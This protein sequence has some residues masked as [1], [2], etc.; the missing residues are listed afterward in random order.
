MLDVTRPA[1]T[2]EVISIG[3][4]LTTGRNLD[5]N[6]QWLSRRLSE[7]GI[8]VKFHTTISDDLAD[9]VACFRIASGRA[10]FVIAT[11]GLGP[12]LDDLTRE[13]FAE[14]AGVGLVEHAESLRVISHMFASRNRPMPERNRVQAL[15]PAGAEVLP[16]RAGTAPGIWLPVGKSVLVAM[17]G[18][19]S[20]MR[21]MYDEQVRPRLEPLGGGVVMQRKINTFGAGESQVEAMLAGVTRRGGN[22]EVGI[23]ASDALISLRIVASAE[24][25]AAADALIAPVEA[26]IRAKLGALVFG[27]DDDTLAGAVV[28]LALAQ[29]ATVAAAESVSG[30][31]AAHRLSGIPGASGT[32][33]GGVVAY[34]DAVKARELGVDPALIAAH[35]A[36]SAEV[37]GA[38]ARG[39]RERF[40]AS[41]GLATTGYA[42]PDAPPDD[43][44]VGTTFAAIATGDGV[45]VERF[46]WPGNRSEVQSRVASF[47]LNLARLHL[48]G[49]AQ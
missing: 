30:G 24:S 25:R 41:I 37:A 11:G 47:A 42:G 45:R 9:N 6:G 32:L 22:P 19:P 39:V 49:A 46:V 40:G 23:T 2:A 1:P 12:T 18:V 10:D 35:T 5:T 8:A 36:V 21:V 44:P 15:F 38:M 43:T 20:E 7:I 28:K 4:E 13:A 27:A 31:L 26:E 29:G 17:P 3:T 16:N 14:V 48:M 33:L 34:T